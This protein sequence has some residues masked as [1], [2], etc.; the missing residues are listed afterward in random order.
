MFWY[1][2]GGGTATPVGLVPG[3]EGVGLGLWDHVDYFVGVYVTFQ[4]QL[5]KLW[6]LGLAQLGGGGHAFHTLFGLCFY[7]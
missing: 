3:F 1:G 2:Y 7:F 5:A 4:E 6:L